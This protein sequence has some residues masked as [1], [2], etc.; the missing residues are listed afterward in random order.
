MHGG[1]SKVRLT[2]KPLQSQTAC[3]SKATK[4]HR[5]TPFIAGCESRKR[6]PQNRRG[7]GTGKK[8]RV[9]DIW[10]AVLVCGVLFVEPSGSFPKRVDRVMPG[11]VET[12]DLR[13][14][15]VGDPAKQQSEFFT[16]QLH[17]AFQRLRFTSIT[18]IVC[19]I[20]GLGAL[21]PVSLLVAYRDSEVGMNDIKLTGVIIGETKM[22]YRI[23]IGGKVSRPV[24][25]PKQY[26]I[27]EKL[28]DA[29]YPE[30][31]YFTIPAWLA[32]K[33]CIKATSSDVPWEKLANF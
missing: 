6:R 11:C 30:L 2:I 33:R 16:A 31:L 3:I 4:S 20:L 26:V 9:S 5:N 23:D 8:P 17:R 25:L 22:A 13:H 7:S 21:N 12:A 29:I 1:A 18:H 10:I 27:R 32:H 19:Y 28:K 24:W 15:Q 14:F